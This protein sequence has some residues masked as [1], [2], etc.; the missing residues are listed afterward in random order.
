MTTKSLFLGLGGLGLNTILYLYSIHPS[1]VD[2]EN[3]S[4]F[5]WL[6]LAGFSIDVPDK[7]VPH[8]EIT[9][10]FC[11]QNTNHFYSA[12]LFN[13]TINRI[14]YY[15]HRFA[16][17][18]H[19]WTLFIHVTAKCSVSDHTTHEKWTSSP[20]EVREIGG[21]ILVWSVTS[22]SLLEST[23]ERSTNHKSL[24]GLVVLTFGKRRSM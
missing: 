24:L 8:R 18:R 5:I 9:V 16:V 2:W 22:L 20:F 4:F 13:W 23:V 10:L 12:E 11:N 19:T 15:K 1:G 3:I 6:Q 7:S 14:L 17:S 21:C